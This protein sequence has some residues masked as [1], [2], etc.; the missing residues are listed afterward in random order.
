MMLSRPD[1][2]TLRALSVQ[3]SCDPRSILAALAGKPVRGLAGERAYAAVQA[4]R[5]K[6]AA[7]S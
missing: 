6:Q 1:W 4:W 3:F 7:A 5:A 2:P